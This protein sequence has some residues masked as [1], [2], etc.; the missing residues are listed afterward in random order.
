MENTPDIII[1][2]K[3]FFET[4]HHHHHYMADIDDK[5][6][7]PNRH[8]HFDD[9]SGRLLYEWEQTLDEVNVFVPTDAALHATRDLNVLVTGNSIEITSTSTSTKKTDDDDDDVVVFPKLRFFRPT[10]ADESVWTRDARTGEIHVQV[11]KCKKAEPWVGAFAAHVVTA[12]KGISDEERKRMMRA[13]FQRDHPGFDFSEAEFEDG[14]EIPDASE[15][16]VK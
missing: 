9:A 6:A 16:N 12:S 2:K 5:L 13:R 3:R 4:H 1:Q 15:W 10:I 7:A 8:K 11:V 14:K